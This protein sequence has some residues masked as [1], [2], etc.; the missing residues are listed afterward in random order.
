MLDTVRGLYDPELR[1]TYRLRHTLRFKAS[2]GR[3]QPG[4]KKSLVIFPP[5]KKAYMIDLIRRLRGRAKLRHEW[6]GT[7]RMIRRQLQKTHTCV[8][9]D[10]Y[11]PSLPTSPSKKL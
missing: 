8:V 7:T 4:R 10:H 6:T 3:P 11:Q 9:I 1:I 5:Q 2:I